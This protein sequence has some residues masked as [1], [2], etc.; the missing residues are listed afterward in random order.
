MSDS[1][2]DLLRSFELQAREQAERAQLLSAR[3]ERHS[4]TVESGDGAVRVTVDSTGGLAALRFGAAAQRLGYERLAELVLQ[5]SQQAQ[6]R[7][8]ASMGEVVSDLYG[9]DSDTARFIS[10]TYT[11]RFPTVEPDEGGE[12]R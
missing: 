9:D 2:E 8:A 12:R 5:T 3:L 10:Q 6:A 1:P 7:L 11:E 4:A